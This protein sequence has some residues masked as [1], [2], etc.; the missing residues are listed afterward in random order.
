MPSHEVLTHI[1]TG[2]R[3]M[4]PPGSANGGYTSGV[5]A[6]HVEGPVATVTLRLPPPLETPLELIRYDGGLR[7]LHGDALVAE[8]VP[9]TLE[10]DPVAPVDLATARVAAAAYRG[11]TDHPFPG[12]PGRPAVKPRP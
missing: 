7:L 9:D 1:V 8:A 6:D 4:G 2:R 12:P 3:H 10:L 11:L 5:L